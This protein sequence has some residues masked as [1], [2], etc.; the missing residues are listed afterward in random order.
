MEVYSLQKKKILF[1]NQVI[2]DDYSNTPFLVRSEALF[3]EIMLVLDKDCY[4]D[5][6]STLKM[7]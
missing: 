3:T 7:K 6:I 2:S 1:N 4:S 5:D